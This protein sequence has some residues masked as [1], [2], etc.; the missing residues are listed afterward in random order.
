MSKILVTPDTMTAA[1]T[2]LSSI[3][4]DQFRSALFPTQGGNSGRFLTTN[5][6]TV[7]W[8]TPTG[9]GG[10]STGTVTSVNVTSTTGLTFNGGPITS[11]GTLTLGGVLSVANGGTGT[12]SIS[13]LA[14]V[15]LPAQSGNSGKFLT[16]NGS[17]TLTWGTPTSTGG[18]SP[19]ASSITYTPVWPGST[20]LTVES[21]LREF[22]SIRDFGA[23][24]D[25]STDDYNAVNLAL[26]SNGVAYMP[27]GRTIT[28]SYLPASG[29]GL[30]YGF[31]TLG[32]EFGGGAPLD[33]RIPAFGP[34]VGRFFA[35]GNR[36]SLIGVSHNDSP[37]GT[38]AM[39]TGTT[40]YGLSTNSGNTVFGLF[41]RADLGLASAP[42]LV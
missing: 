7:A 42:A 17:G 14:A 13:G 20:T 6:S 4:Q 23:K 32:G 29:S 3:Q 36:N 8:G 34:A 1:F 19:L 24:S 11:S 10:G 33:G 9:T 39:P 37:A 16:T 22:R 12:T 30:G 25:G 38:M 35:M 26:T 31:F 2:S 18:G 28:N 40:G 15:I 5:G 41:G 21:K 27:Y